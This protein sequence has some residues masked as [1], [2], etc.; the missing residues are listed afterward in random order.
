MP[1]VRPLQQVIVID[2]GQIVE[3]GTHKELIALN[4]VYRRLVIRQ[5]QAGKG[6]DIL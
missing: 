6:D 3:Q 5:L 2:K 1:P 4:G